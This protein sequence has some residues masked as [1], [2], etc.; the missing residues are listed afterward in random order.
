MKKYYVP[1]GV[2]CTAGDE[3][4]L[5]CDAKESIYRDAYPVEAVDTTGA[6]DC[7]LAGFIYA[8]FCKRMDK[9]ETIEFASASAALKCMQKGPRTRATVEDVLQFIHSNK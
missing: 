7:F 5:W 2:I 6:G 9:Q 1:Q 4:A 8:Y 3:G